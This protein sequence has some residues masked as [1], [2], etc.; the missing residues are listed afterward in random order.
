[1]SCCYPFS[2]APANGGVVYYIDASFGFCPLNL[3][4]NSGPRTAQWLGSFLANVNAA[5]VTDG[6]PGWVSSNLRAAVDHQLAFRTTIGTANEKIVA[7]V[8]GFNNDAFGDQALNTLAFT[9]ALI[10]DIFTWSGRVFAMD[11][12]PV[13]NRSLPFLTDGPTQLD[14]DWWDNTYRPAYR[15][16]C[17]AAGAT[18]L[19]VFNDWQPTNVVRPP[20][21]PYPDFHLDSPSAHRAAERLFNYIRPYLPTS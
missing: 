16:A 19:Q 13:G 1:M 18:V 11:Y 4:C 7:S 2:A 21:A 17:T 8:L 14:P 3:A 20:Q 5:L 15:S 12:P 10:A 9:Q 6:F